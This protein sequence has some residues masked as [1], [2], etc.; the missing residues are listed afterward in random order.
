MPSWY[1]I[2]TEPSCEFAARRALENL[3][4]RVFL[5]WCWQRRLVAHRRVTVKAAWFARYLF[6][7]LAPPAAGMVPGYPPT[8]DILAA[9]GVASLLGETPIPDAIMDRLIGTA[10]P[11]G[12]MPKPQ[13]KPGDEVLVEALGR[14][15]TIESLDEKS[16]RVIIPL[17]GVPRYAKIP[18]SS[19]DA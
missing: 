10:R 13:L 5:P 1:A 19:L 17:F 18:R 11:D 15:A 2:H 8:R 9:R 12:E 3:R 7:D 4:L 14:L 16:I 6:A